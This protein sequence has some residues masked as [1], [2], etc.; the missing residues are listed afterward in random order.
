MKTSPPLTL[1]PPSTSEML[2]PIIFR[3]ND[4]TTYHGKGLHTDS[5]GSG[6]PWGA[7]DHVGRHIAVGECEHHFAA[8]GAGGSADLELALHDHKVGKNVE[9]ALGAH[10][11]AKRQNAAEVG[12]NVRR[13][14]K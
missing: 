13:R 2:I 4:D 14:Q 12:A 3:R 8:V 1:P 5:G 6:S 11:A 10:S 9:G 7:G